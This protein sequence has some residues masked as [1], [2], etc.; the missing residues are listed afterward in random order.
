MSLRAFPQR[1][2][3]GLLFHNLRACDAP[4]MRKKKFLALQTLAITEPPATADVFVSR[5]VLTPFPKDD[6]FQIRG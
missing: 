2:R 3:H 4:A 5:I 6:I 1:K